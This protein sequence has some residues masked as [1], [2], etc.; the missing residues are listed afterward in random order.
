VA[1]SVPCVDI[2]ALIAGAVRQKPGGTC[3][4]G[5]ALDRLEPAIA[6]K[7]R[8]VIADT[9]TFAVRGVMA[10]FAGLGLDV[11][12]GPLERHR[13]QECACVQA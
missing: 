13:R 7:V 11:G 2:D 9:D 3:T 12:R 4:V 5:I 10:V 1:R 6:V 8:A